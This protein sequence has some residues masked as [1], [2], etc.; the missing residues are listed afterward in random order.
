[1][2]T[3]VRHYGSF[4]H[5]RYKKNVVCYEI[6][7]KVSI[8]LIGKA[9]ILEPDCTVTNY[10]GGLAVFHYWQL[11]S[12]LEARWLSDLAIQGVYFIL[13]TLLF[14]GRLLFLLLRQCLRPMTLKGKK[15]ILL[16]IDPKS[17]GAICFSGQQL[18]GENRVPNVKSLFCQVKDNNGSMLFVSM[19]V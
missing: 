12:S 11:A 2:V 6:I 13:F 17:F 14:Y 9:A 1:M 7:Y 15:R 10:H 5:K 19:I 4:G 8:V 16:L 3:V 18:N